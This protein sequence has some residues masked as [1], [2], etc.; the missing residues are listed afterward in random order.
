PLQPVVHWRNEPDRGY[1]VVKI[2]T[3]DRAGLFSKIAGSFSAAGLSI[4]S[5]RIFTR[6]DGIVLDTFFAVDAK[7][8]SLIGRERREEFER[9]LGTVLIEGEADLPVLIA[10]HQSA[11][12]LWQAYAGERL[13]TQIRFD[14]ESS[15]SRTL[16][17]IETEDR[18]GLLYAIC[19]TLAVLDLDI[20]SA[21]ILT[22]K[23]AAIDSF[24]VRERDGRQVTGERQKQIE[25]R[26]RQAIA[27]L[28]A[29]RP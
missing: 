3:W 28:D 23:G 22:E 5:A 19:Q 26:L 17:E 13:P 20:S 12:P 27:S 8:G 14:N 1:S 2:C 7:T 15:E 24:Y 16:I 11:R 9:L 29:S 18:V 6:Q 10:R 21:K 4:L 25:R